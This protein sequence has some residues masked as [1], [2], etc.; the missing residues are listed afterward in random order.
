MD[1]IQKDSVRQ[2]IP[3]FAEEIKNKKEQAEPPRTWVIE[4]RRERI[5]GKERPV[6]NVPIELLRFRKDN[7]RI[8]SDVLSY[9]KEFELFHEEDQKSQ[10]KIGEFLEKKDSEKTAELEKSIS[11]SGQKEPAIITCDGFL[12]NGN[13][14]KLAFQR[15]LERTHDYEKYGYMKVAILPCD[16]EEGGPPTVKEIELLENKYQLQ[17]EG[18]SEYSNFNQALSLRKKISLGISLEELLKDDSRYSNQTEKEFAK[19]VQSYKD[20]YLGPLECVDRYLEYLN[21]QGLYDTIGEGPDGRW[22][23]FL[24]YYKSVYKFFG[25]ENKRLSLNIAEDEIGRINDA[26]FKMIRLR[27]FPKQK[28][29]GLMRQMPKLLRNNDSKKEL[30]RINSQPEDISE[31]EKIDVDGKQLTSKAIDQKWGS[32]VGEFIINDV[33]RAAD[34]LE[35]KQET[36]EPLGLLDSA[37]KKLNHEEMHIDTIPVA[38]ILKAMELSRCIRE[39]A[40]EIEHELFSFK[41]NSSDFLKKHAKTNQNRHQ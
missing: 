4:F 9:E 14:R 2:I 33:K 35:W 40:L 37:L 30:L 13:R 16:G 21:R 22:Q 17:K 3:D 19:T 20:E 24:D 18:K 5:Q 41:K 39:R 12:I 23:A 31:D 6:Y 11:H 25:S 10:D 34:L 29:H 7:G 8:S 1:R 32:Q 36:E 27:T 28:V 15:L 38:N 26:A